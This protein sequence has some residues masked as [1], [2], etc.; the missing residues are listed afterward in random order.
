MFKL[1][2]PN[3]NGSYV[4]DC[5]VRAISIAND[6]SW[7][8]TYIDLC[9]RGLMLFDMPSSNRVWNEYL[10]SEGYTRHMVP[11][12]CPHC[13]TIKDFCNEYFRGTYI[14][15]TGTHVVAVINGDYYDTWDSGDESP[16]YFWTKEEL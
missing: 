1:A 4:G 16:I 14:L 15:G 7:N 2:N 13:Y 10:K 6:K 5:V 9:L 8:E 11:D 12:N 3:P